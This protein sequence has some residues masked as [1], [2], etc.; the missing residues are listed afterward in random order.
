MNRPMLE[1][2]RLNVPAHV[3]HTR[4]IEWVAQIAA[5]TEARDV[6]WCDG[7]QAEYDALCRQ[8]VE[9]GTMLERDQEVLLHLARWRA[10]FP[11]AY[12]E[13]VRAGRETTLKSK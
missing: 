6:Y 1:G 12:A 3:R 9:S 10:A 5:L 4:L 7:S 13:W 8:L 11:D 2:L